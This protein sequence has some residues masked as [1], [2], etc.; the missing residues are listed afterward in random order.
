MIE[1]LFLVAYFFALYVIFTGGDLRWA[2]DE[3]E[4]WRGTRNA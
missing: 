3:I 2:I 1:F 4:D